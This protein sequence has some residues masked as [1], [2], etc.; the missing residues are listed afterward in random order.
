VVTA[1]IEAVGNASPEYTAIAKLLSSAE[2]IFM[3]SMKPRSS[4]CERASPEVV[5]LLVAKGAPVNARSEDPDSN[6]VLIEAA[7]GGSVETLAL[8]LNAGADLKA[9]N[10]KE[11]LL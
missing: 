2:L 3:L 1:L 8:L 10:N 11:R 7:S 5:R 9:T 4:R 6:T